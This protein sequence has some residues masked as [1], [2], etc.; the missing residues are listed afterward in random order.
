MGATLVSRRARTARLTLLT[1]LALL[2]APIAC[3]SAG[4]QRAF[5]ALDGTGARKRTAFFTDTQAIWCDAQ[6]SSGRTDLS[7]DVRIRATR[8]WSDALQRLEP[9]DL[10]IANGELA[11]QEG[12]GGVAGFQWVQQDATGKAAPAGAI[13]YPVGDFAC[14]VMLDGQLASS[15]PFTISFPTCPV[16]PVEEGAQCA[17]WVASGSLCSDPVGRQCRCAT[18]VWTC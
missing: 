11:A 17:G 9:I 12:V 18:G 1:L 4:L 6:Y 5:M 3:D 2:A 8:L 13:P 16:P 15:L 14:D 10:V 7:I